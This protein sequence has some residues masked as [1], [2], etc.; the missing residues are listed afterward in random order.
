MK[1]VK[2]I[3]PLGIVA[4]GLLLSNGAMSQDQNP[5]QALTDSAWLAEDIN[6]AGVLDRLQSTLIFDVN[7]NVAGN[8]GCNRYFGSATV[9]DDAIKFGQLGSTMMACSEAAMD[10]EQNFLRAL[11]A[12]RSWRIDAERNLLYLNNEEGQTILRFS[13]LTEPD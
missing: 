13:R 9:S 10:Q 1:N 6:N 3:C 11:E 7:L 2:N 8:G 4:F 5:Q 12:A